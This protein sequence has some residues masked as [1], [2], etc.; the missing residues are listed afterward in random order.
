MTDKVLKYCMRGIVRYLDGDVDKFNEY[1]NKAIE[2]EKTTCECGGY[3]IDCRYDR[4]KARICTEC[5]R[6][7]RGKKVVRKCLVNSRRA[8]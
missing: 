8:G 1:V 5:G 7:W 3:M 6:I 2:I 4:E